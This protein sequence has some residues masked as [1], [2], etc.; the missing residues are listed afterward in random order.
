MVF[1]KNNLCYNNHKKTL[2]AKIR[3]FYGVVF[4]N[5]FTVCCSAFMAL[6]NSCGGTLCYFSKASHCPLLRIWLDKIYCFA[7]KKALLPSTLVS[8]GCAD[9]KIL[10]ISLPSSILSSI[11]I[12]VIRTVLKFLISFYDKISEV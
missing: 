6:P 7:L 3:C 8:R 2:E 11:I 1:I 5:Q 4:H 12:E 9:F 10:W